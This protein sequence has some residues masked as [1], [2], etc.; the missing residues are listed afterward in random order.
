L[1]DTKTRI[2]HSL[3]WYRDEPPARIRVED[4]AI[5]LRATSRM[6][7]RKSFRTAYTE[8]AEVLAMTVLVRESSGHA[9]QG[10]SVIIAVGHHR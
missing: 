1:T 8:L 9:T 10:I 4:E 5:S 2:K 7:E 3:T 6:T